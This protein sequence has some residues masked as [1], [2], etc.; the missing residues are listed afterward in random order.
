[1][2]MDRFPVLLD[3]PT[4]RLDPHCPTSVP[5]DSVAVH[6]ERA[7]RN[8]GQSL[9]QLAGRGGL[10]PRELLAVVYA[11]DAESAGYVPARAGVDL[12]RRMNEAAA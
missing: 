3:A 6:D 4:R 2:S 11:L 1:M 9:A 8:H 7:R 5:W 12:V 10:T